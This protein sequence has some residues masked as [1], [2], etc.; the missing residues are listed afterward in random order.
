MEI[1]Q[2]GY[3]P[4]LQVFYLNDGLR[5]S[6]IQHPENMDFVN[7]SA[8]STSSPRIS[9]RFF[10]PSSSD[11]NDSQT[12]TFADSQIMFLIDASNICIQH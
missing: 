6:I 8:I 2:N 1:P 11:R 5:A 10:W 12:G 9:C 3:A 7:I 4:D